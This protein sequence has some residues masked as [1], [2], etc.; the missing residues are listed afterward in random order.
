MSYYSIPFDQDMVSESI[1]T[2]GNIEVQH[3][4]CDLFIRSRVLNCDLVQTGFSASFRALTQL[5]AFDDGESDSVTFMLNLKGA[6]YYRINGLDMPRILPGNSLAIC[7]AQEYSGFCRYQ[8]QS[9]DL[10]TL[11]VPR[12]L[13]IDYLEIMNLDSDLVKQLRNAEPFM[14]IGPAD[15]VLCH[16]VKKLLQLNM[17]APTPLQSHLAHAFICDACRQLMQV[18]QRQARHDSGDVLEK[19][20]QILDKDFAQPLT[21]TEL[22]K[23]SGTNETSLKLWFR[24][25]LNTTVHQYMLQRRMAE[26]K[27]LLEQQLPVS[28]VAQEVGYS[29]HGHFAAAF[30]KAFGCSPSVMSRSQSSGNSQAD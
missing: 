23:R 6:V 21:I 5:E 22:A 25:E 9:N 1:Q 16:Q 17:Q 14:L 8:H 27:V 24:R 4:C 30:K 28:F 18:N 7:Y 26:A 3:R 13:L 20:V 11:Q 2:N 10:F 15:K 19:A 12:S 29:N